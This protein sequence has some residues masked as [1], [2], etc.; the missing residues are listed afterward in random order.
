MNKATDETAAHKSFVENIGRL[1]S[2][3]EVMREEFRIVIGTVNLR[4]ERLLSKLEAARR[5][6][7]LPL[8]EQEV[9]EEENANDRSARLEAA[10]ALLS[11]WHVVMLVTFTEAYLED[12]LAACAAR[13]P[14]LMSRS[15]QTVGYGDVRAATSVEE[16]L[17]E[18]RHRWARNFVDD[19]GPERWIERLVRMGARGYESNDA[20]ALEELWG[21]RHVVV[22]AAGRATRDFVRRHPRLGFQAGARLDVGTTLEADYYDPLFRF[23]DTTDFFLVRR[24]FSDASGTG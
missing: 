20:E 7:I 14:E 16:L 5:G 23:V 18:I 15:E 9:A 24:Y 13:D 8:G 17:D 11:D 2:L 1:W 22:H 21:I 10:D 4:R 19:G 12:V 3:F 6:D